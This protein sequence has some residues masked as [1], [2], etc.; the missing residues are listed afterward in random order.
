M[1]F[2]A[3]NYW[4]VLAAAVAN[5]VIGSLWYGPVFGAKWQAYLGLS[6]D[7]MH[8]MPLTAKQA[9]VGGSITALVM[10]FV[11]AQ[12]VFGLGI[13]MP[14]EALMLAFWLWLGFGVTLSAGSFLWEGRPLGL[15]VLNAAH[16]LVSIVVMT[17]ILAWWL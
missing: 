10:S 14:L 3:L 8:K 7:D 9:M 1:G 4:A 12:L 6:K 2:F 15:F 13:I 16:W 11:I 17:L 5:M